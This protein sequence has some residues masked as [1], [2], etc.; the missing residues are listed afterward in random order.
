MDGVALSAWQVGQPRTTEVGGW[1]LEPLEPRLLLA[2]TVT[3]SLP[4]MVVAANHPAYTV[5]VSSYFSDP[6]LPG[7]LVEFNTALGVIPVILYDVADGVHSTAPLTV[8]NFLHYVNGDAGYGTY[9]NSIVHRSDHSIV[10]PSLPAE[11]QKGF[12]IQGGGYHYLNGLWGYVNPSST[13]TTVDNEYDASR[14]NVRG[15]IAMALSSNIDSATDQWF[16]NLGDNSSVLDSQSFTVFGRIIGSGMD[17]VDA[18]SALPIYDYS[19]SLYPA[20]NQLPLQG[21]SDSIDSYSVVGI[22]TVRVLAD[23][24]T[25]T[26]QTDSPDLLSASIT[27][28]SLILNPMPGQTGSGHITV[29]AHALDGST[30]D[31]T[32][33]VTVGAADHPPILA[34]L[35][36]SPNPVTR[37]VQTLL[38][39]ASGVSDPGGSVARVEFWRDA[40]ANGLF[41]PATD[42]LLGI[43]PSAAGGWT[44]QVATTG[45]SYGV[46]TIFARAI[47]NAGNGSAP[48]QAAVTVVTQRPALTAISGYY[49]PERNAS[50]TITYSSLKSKSNASDANGDTIQFRIEQVL[51]GTLTKNGS[52]VV[53]G[54]TL[55][56]AGDSIVWTPPSATGYFYNA[57]S[58]KAFDGQL[59]S[60]RAARVT[61]QINRP[62]TVFHARAI[63][64]PI[65]MPGTG[66]TLTARVSGPNTSLAMV[67]FYY[68]T[69]GSGSLDT[70]IDRN[71]GSATF[72]G[73]QWVLTLDSQA[74]QDLP[75]GPATFFVRATDYYGGTGTLKFATTINAPPTI[76]SLVLSDPVYRGSRMTLTASDVQDT[77]PG[78]VRQVA[79][80]LDINGNGVADSSDWRLGSAYSRTTTY[81]LS[82]STRGFPVGSVQF[83]AVAVDSNNG[84]ATAA[85]TATINNSPPTVASL[86]ASLASVARGSPVLLTAQGVADA[87]GSVT[88]VEFWSQVAAGPFDVG[89]ATKI[90]EDT[91]ATGGWT[92]SYT[93]PTGT[94]PGTLQIFARAIDNDLLAG[95]AAGTTLTIT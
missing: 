31:S 69:D 7:T 45:W 20:F 1:H 79:F 46:N 11:E 34:A 75:A 43:D 90:G 41:D 22:S 30:V 84:T 80:F 78:V 2:A 14:P 65:T 85:A 10:D 23:K 25:Y 83:L 9:D 5:G 60:D 35:R 6:A 67:R 74:T 36:A 48:A 76:G 93:I 55:I 95:P 77:A 58:V 54:V 40:N 94:A 32:F 59:V 29:T 33:L 71:L 24:L 81:A 88:K 61:V 3:S 18:I 47:D 26:V 91:S 72:T 16:I 62:P 64:S 50:Y 82:V 42:T 66:I 86:L 52:P 38:L 12:V 4:D 8:T 28:G 44:L 63:P 19:Q 73:G 92:L 51:S 21:S 56:G 15:S 27:G 17:V 49:M 70:S 89:S 68:D 13:P 39:T 53:P 37:D 87:D 57:F